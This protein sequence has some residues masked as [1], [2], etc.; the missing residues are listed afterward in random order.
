M[1]TRSFRWFMFV[2][3][4]G[5]PFCA[6]TLTYLIRSGILGRRRFEISSTSASFDFEHPVG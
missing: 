6:K 3:L 1:A 4:T 5:T 2:V